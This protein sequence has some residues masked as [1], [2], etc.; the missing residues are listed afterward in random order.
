[1]DR[2]RRSLGVLGSLCNPPHLGHLVLAQEATWQ[3]GLDGVLLVPTGVPAHRM[4]PPEPAPLRL[5]LAE[6]AATADPLL[7]ASAIEVD[8]SG[9]SYMADTLE[10]LADGEDADLVLLLGAD[11]YAAFETWHEPERVRAASRI[12]V[13]PRPGGAGVP[14]DD[15]IIPLRMPAIDISS[16][17]IRRRVAAG[18]PVRHLV[19][20]AV[21]GIIEQEGLYRAPHPDDRVADGA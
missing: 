7:V 6:A 3:L 4:P 9:P 13:A 19:P 12:A 16:S 18:E 1:M 5:R 20:D 10:V 11:Q 2:R 8:R 17:G 21:R 14:A 15:R